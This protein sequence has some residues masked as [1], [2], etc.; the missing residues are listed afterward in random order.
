MWSLLVENYRIEIF[1]KI[2]QKTTAFYCIKLTDLF[3][4]PNS[5]LI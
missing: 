5:N 3:F 1:L 2:S 4:N